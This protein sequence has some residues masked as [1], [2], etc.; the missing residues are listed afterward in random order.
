M[1]RKEGEK[2]C[3]LESGHWPGGKGVEKV[4][5]G[6]KQKNREKKSAGLGRG[7]RPIDSKRG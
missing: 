7:H 4:E 1:S 5:E 3:G 6:V 2:S